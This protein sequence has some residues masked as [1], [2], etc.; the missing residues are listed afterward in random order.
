MTT[1]NGMLMGLGG[2]RLL[3]LFSQRGGTAY[4]DIFLLN[5]ERVDDPLH[6]LRRAV[7][8]G[9]VW[10]Q[11]ADGTTF[12]GRLPLDRL[13]HHEE[14]HSQQWGE[15]GYGGFLASYAWEQIRGKNDTEEDAGLGDGGYR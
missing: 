5:V 13:L 2:D 9:R 4:G 7:R 1:P 14:R 8:S 12:A 10:R 3:G 6:E 15:E 11:R